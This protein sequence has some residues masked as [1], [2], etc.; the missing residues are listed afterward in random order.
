[1]FYDDCLKI[2]QDYFSDNAKIFLDRQISYHLNKK[3]QDLVN[4]DKQ[5]LAYWLRV[6]ASLT[7]GK[8]KANDLVEKI[9]S[10]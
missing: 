9:M 5:E 2:C 10:L 1:M 6:S 8:E 4:T 7:I 3:P